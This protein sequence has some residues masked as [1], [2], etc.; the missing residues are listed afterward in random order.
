VRRT[1]RVHS[2]RATTGPVVTER[3]R[4]MMID[5]ILPE[6]RVA[7]VDMPPTEGL[8]RDIMLSESE[9]QDESVSEMRDVRC[10]GHCEYIIPVELDLV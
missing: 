9:D 8:G 6:R 3:C 10:E 4:G 2:M 1:P 7:Q 5:R